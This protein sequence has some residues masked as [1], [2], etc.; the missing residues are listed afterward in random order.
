MEN[1]RIAIRD[2]TDS[3]N[4]AFFDNI[5]G[6]RY[7]SANLQR[8]LAGSASI[9]TIEYNSKDIDTIRTGCK[10]AFIYKERAYWLN[11]MDLSKK[12]YKVEITAYSIGLELNQ[13]ERGAHKPANAMNF[14][15][16][17]GY[18]DPEHA[19][20]IGVN[21]VADKRIKL[22]WTG[23]D[24]I[25]ARLFSIANSFDAELEFTV[26]LNQDYSLKRQVLNV[27]K[28]GNLGSNR[29]A[30]PIRV[31][32]G[33]KVINYS[34]NLKELRTA[35]RA[36]GKDGLTIDGLNKKVYDDD[37]NLLYYSN[38][39]TV[40]A[41]QSRDKYP[42]VGKKSNDNWIIK[43]LGET[44]YSTK[45]ALW[46]YMLGELKKICV[47]EITYDIEGA[48]DG[49]V[50]DT[51]TLIDDVHYDPPL[52]VQ[53]RISELT[54][55][56]TTGK[57]T[58]STLTNFERKYSQVASELIKQ[59][60]QLANDAAP[61]IIRLETNNGFNFK[62]GKGS[63]TV[64]ASL[65]K[66]GKIVGASWKWLINN[67]VV[68]E[69]SSVTIN[70]SQ[71]T[72]TLNVV[73]VAS[74]D[75]NEVAREYITFTNS[76]DGVGIKSI[77]RYY[78]TNDQSEG[79]TT[80]GQNWST[81]PTTV[82]ADKNYMWS[83]DVITYTNDTSLVTEPAVI[84]AR[85]DDGLD[86][87]T[88]GI[89][90]ALDKAKQEL[91]AL[92]ANIE[93]VRDDSLAAVEEA[94]QQ[95]ATV[96]NDLSKA[97]TD[98]QNAVSAVDTKATNLQ[99]DLTTAKQDLQGQASQLTEQASAQSELTKR[100]TTV[101]TTANGTKTTVNELTKTVAQN[102]KDITSVT[103][104][105]KTVEDDLANTKTTL[106]QVQT[107]A[108][109][110]S[111]KT[112][113]L[114]TGLNGLTA[115][116]ETLKIG[117][118]NYFKNSK[119]RKYYIDSTETQD[120]RSFIDDE[121]WQ[122]DT[123]FT[124]N[125]VRMSFDIAFNPALPS[126]FTTNVH[127]GASPWYNCGGITFK[128]GTTALQH[129]DLKFDLSGASNSYK[130]DNIFIRLN[131]TLPL[132]TA[133]SLENF[134]LYL[135]A[136][137]ED[138]K[139]NEADIESKVAEYKQTADQNYASLSS[140]V[141]NLDGTVQQNKS[142]FDQTAQGFSTRIESLE[143]YKDGETTRANQ[144]FELAKTETARQLTA[145]RTAIAKDY[146]AKSTYT[147]DVTGIR[148]DLT[149][150]T[151][152]ANTTKT[153]LANYQAS[154]DKAVANLQS[155][156]Q[157]ANGNISSLQTKVEAVPGQITS[158]VSSV[159]GKIPTE[160]GSSNLLRNTAVNAENL[161]LF[162]K[163]DTTVNVVEKDGHQVYKLVVSGSSNAG[164]YF[165]GNNDYYNLV[166]DRSYTFSLWVL[167]NKDK[168]YNMYSLGHI[169]AVNTNGDNVGNDILHQHTQPVYSTNVIKANTWTKV[170][171]T[172]KAT[173]NSFFR[174]YFWYL[175]AGD[176]IY[177]YD[178][179][180]NEGKIPLSYTP[181]VE[182]TVSQISTL[183]TTLN[184][185]AEG[186]T[187]LSTKV[188]TQG[189]TITSHTNSINS[190]STGLS[191]KVSQTDFNTLSS[192]V[193]TAENNIT[194]KAN[195]LSS[196]ITSVEGKI[197][198]S[199][200]GTNLLL[201]SADPWKAPNDYYQ[202]A[203]A[204]KT[205]ETLNGSIVYKTNRA[206]TSLRAN[207]GKQLIDRKN[208]KVGDEF[209]YSIYAKTDQNS[210]KVLLVIRFSGGGET[211]PLGSDVSLTNEWQKFSVTFKVTE[212]MVASDTKL[213]WAGFEQTTNCEDGKYV[214]YACNKL[215]RGNVATDYSPSPE[216]Y[217][218]ALTQAKSEIKQTTDAITASVSSVQTAASNAQS[219]ANTAVSK[220]DAA[221]AGVN[222]LD[223]TT[224]KS[225]SLNL[226]NNGFVTKVGK[227]V[228]G[229]T[230]ATMIAQNESD[231]QI[232]AKKMKVSGDMIVNGA[233]TAEKLNV[234][235]LSA[236]NSNLGKIEGGS[237]LLQ[238][239]KAASSSIDSWGTFNRPA[240]KQGLYMDNHGLASS[241]AIQRKNS[242]ETMPTDM[243]LAVLQSG[244]LRFLVVDY[245]DNLENVLHYGLS[246]P[247]FGAIRFEID[248]ELKRRLTMMSSGY[249][250]FQAT[251]YTNWTSTGV[252][253]CEYMIQGRLVLV[254]YDVTFNSAGTH[255][256]GGIPQEF[257][258][259]S[260]MMTA[261]AWTITPRDKNIQLNSDGTLHILDAEANV[262]Y[263][264]TLVFSY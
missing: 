258:K 251:N 243:P 229:N 201:Y 166:K 40:Y 74:V 165:N 62:N 87:D 21:E 126:N 84:G 140:T 88:T 154:N 193:T 43:E 93:K 256:I 263:R 215:D 144:Y 118:R 205:D 160:I 197:P 98:L 6:I 13:E 67:S 218:A 156:L 188:D 77:K 125:Y 200:G 221:Q 195:E 239:N 78:T 47:P 145:E 66:Y 120:V 53:G 228:N 108:N 94:K 2:S 180:L 69:T 123:R 97:K 185:T 252:N 52:Y 58:K 178:M 168:N 172:F 131:N 116:F 206:W 55:D 57:V 38:A 137:V 28:K 167:T 95:L 127:F 85:G 25:L 146:V 3:H 231:V 209:T 141:Q 159:E 1:V 181:A 158:A 81:K 91:S 50:G 22:E 237:L 102:G 105:T 232:I 107:T 111:Q 253:G 143:T 39:N 24:T 223:N 248:S 151:T 72:G 109:S 11:I 242:G 29:A 82:T 184:Q 48:V 18:Y 199:V 34:D 134:N 138:Y 161:K 27:Y 130:T 240:H 83:Y 42:S 169:Q 8:F 230:F 23:T 227:T 176:E 217:D 219:T 90:E 139:Q 261:K 170:W 226:D 16:Y 14:A 96:A 12:G 103:N 60:E 186:L 92:S 113:T 61:Y 89:T 255:T 259:K 149:A 249:L 117:N 245:N 119:S 99:S 70:A 198:T 213:T 20:E 246:D 142:E 150:T 33:L 45:E 147:S 54:E 128:G 203:G 56:L 30:S 100:V 264:G 244:E 171:C 37:G 124:E 75:G 114:E 234:S 216:D 26:E 51:R 153:N 163:T 63:S 202:F 196:K 225:A 173:S 257:T 36:T 15:E 157:T 44:E 208:V 207:W 132:N 233:I 152:T 204:T 129:F 175:T 262:N 49:D 183:N 10:L 59:V 247:D 135:S 35:V 155:N 187:Q 41:P 190:L 164:A 68:S 76:D 122:N 179:M 189:S 101:E 4:V 211:A 148:N 162:G 212:K 7:Q 238:E 104:R 112:A 214:Y 224:V 110:A 192:R 121:F 32:R 19:L 9:L 177:I 133:V 182:D 73:A 220:A 136:V 17:L 235:N 80:G 46:G 79:V 5:S 64:T 191:A 65:E 222:T 254:N 236:V 194:A 250:N 210:M 71:V 115:K 106:T 260:L 31:G 174:P 86:A 241:G